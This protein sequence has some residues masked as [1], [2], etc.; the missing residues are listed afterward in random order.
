MSAAAVKPS[1]KAAVSCAAASAEEKRP[2]R[3][4]ARPDKTKTSSSVPTNYRDCEWKG[5]RWHE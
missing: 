1:A 5:K 2:K 4:T 3:E